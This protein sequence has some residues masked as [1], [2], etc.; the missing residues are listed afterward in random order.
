MAATVGSWCVRKRLCQGG[1]GH[2]VEKKW[3]Q[4][5]SLF[6]PG[7]T[8]CPTWVPYLGALLGIAER[9]VGFAGVLVIVPEIDGIAAAIVAAALATQGLGMHGQ[10]ILLGIAQANVL[11]VG[12]G[13]HM[14]GGKR[15][16][17]AEGLHLDS[18]NPRG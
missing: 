2:P 12:G 10:Q 3:E 16:G 17:E 5:E 6:W 4:I 8:A 9:N 11:V 18:Q 14:V 1:A 13:F 15:I 7:G